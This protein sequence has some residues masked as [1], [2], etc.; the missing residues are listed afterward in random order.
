MSFPLSKPRTHHCELD[1]A[2]KEEMRG[3]GK[4]SEETIHVSVFVFDPIEDRWYDGGMVTGS[5]WSRLEW[6]IVGS[7]MLGQTQFPWISSWRWP[8]EC[9]VVLPAT[10][11]RWCR[12]AD[13]LC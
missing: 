2:T 12:A 10:S 8:G 7:E 3:A 9:W 13:C 6:S 1:A 4:W 5:M 11:R